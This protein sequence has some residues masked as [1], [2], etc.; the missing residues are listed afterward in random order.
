M[1]TCATNPAIIGL[2]LATITFILGLL[3]DVT[4]SPKL[5]AVKN[6]FSLASAPMEILITILYWGISAVSFP[7][8]YYHVP[9]L[10]AD[11]ILPNI[12]TLFDAGARNST[13]PLERILCC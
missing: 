8:L 10:H 2:V 13:F 4:M 3:S 12:I 7:S 6:L 1:W 5:F 9:L 11:S